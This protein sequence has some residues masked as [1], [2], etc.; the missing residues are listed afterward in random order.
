MVSM[1]LG[2]INRLINRESRNFD[3]FNG[4]ELYNDLRKFIDKIKNIQF[5]ILGN[6]KFY[7]IL[8]KIGNTIKIALKQNKNLYNNVRQ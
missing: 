7:K 6:N 2:D 1:I 4:F 5:L 8:L 3:F